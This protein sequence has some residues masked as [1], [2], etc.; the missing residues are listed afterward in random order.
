MKKT[1]GTIYDIITSND[2]RNAAEMIFDLVQM[3]L[4][5]LQEVLRSD[6]TILFGDN[7]DDLITDFIEKL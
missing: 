7:I 5:D 1:I 4:L 3:K 2:D 6:D